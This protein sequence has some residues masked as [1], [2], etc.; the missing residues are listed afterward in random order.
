MLKKSQWK[1]F[2]STRPVRGG[3]G[4]TVTVVECDGF[5]STRPV[6]GGTGVGIGQ[7]TKRLDFNPP[8]PCGAGLGVTTSADMIRGISIHPPRAGRDQ[9]NTIA[10]HRGAIS[11]HPPRAGR[12]LPCGLLPELPQGISIHPPRAGRDRCGVHRTRTFGGFQSTRPVR[13]GTSVTVDSM[14]EVTISIHPPRAG[15]DRSHTACTLDACISI[16]P[17]RAGRDG[18]PRAPRQSPMDFNPPAPC[19]AGP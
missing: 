18:R 17:P 12:D 13:G 2:Q 3:T 15:R 11:I 8:A 4:Q 1:K 6:R 9:C 16:H 5:Q 19:G 7:I 10:A 14:T